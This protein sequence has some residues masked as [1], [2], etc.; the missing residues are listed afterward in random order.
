MIKISITSQ[1]LEVLFKF[2]LRYVAKLG[3]W[4]YS[5]ISILDIQ[6]AFSGS[7]EVLLFEIPMLDK[8]VN[9]SHVYPVWYI[10]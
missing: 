6:A 1:I 4:H 8:E 5:V 9:Q 3:V 10:L 7:L 2:L